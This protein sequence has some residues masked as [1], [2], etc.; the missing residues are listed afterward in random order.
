MIFR[1]D[2]IAVVVSLQV[3]IWTYEVTRMRNVGMYVKQFAHLIYDSLIEVKEPCPPFLEE[4]LDV[5]SIIVEECAL[6]V[7]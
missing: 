2:G 3:S 1:T 5:I 6:T 7:C 4:G